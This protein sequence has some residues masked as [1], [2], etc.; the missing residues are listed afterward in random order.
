MAYLTSPAA[1][2]ITAQALHIDG[3]WLPH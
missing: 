3:G 2:F 1:S